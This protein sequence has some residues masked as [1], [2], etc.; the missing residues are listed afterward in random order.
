MTQVINTTYHALDSSAALN[1]RASG[2]IRAGVYAGYRIRPN[3]G[4]NNTLDIIAGT[5]SSSIL[6][7]SQGIRIEETESVLGAVAIDAADIS[8]TRVD[9]VVASYTYQSS[10]SVPQAYT[11][12]KGRNQVNTSSDP[13]KPTVANSLQIP[14]AYVTVRPK[15]QFSGVVTSRIEVTDIEHVPNANWPDANT[16][17]VVAPG[18]STRVYVYPGIFLS[19]DQRSVVEFPGGY[20]DAQDA[21]LYT[22]NEVRYIQFGLTDEGLVENV[23]ES[24]TLAA[25]PALTRDVFPVAIAKVRKSFNTV[26]IESLTD[27]RFPY[28]RKHSK[29]DEEDDYK[30]L[31]ADSVFKSMRVERLVDDSAIDLD[32]VQ[33][34]SSGTISTLTAAID[35]KDTS[36]TLTWAGTSALPS[37]AV[38]ISTNELLTGGNTQTLSH[39][40]IAADA[41][42]E[43]IRYQYSTS[44]SDSGFTATTYRL[45]E[46]VRIPAGGSTRLYLRF[47]FPRIAFSGTKQAKL[48][49]FAVLMNLDDAVLNAN[50]V[51]ELGIAALK[52]SVNNLIPNGNFYYWSR[53]DIN[54]SDPDLATTGDINF[55][56]SEYL[57]EINAADGWQVTS[58]GSGPQNNMVTRTHLSDIGIPSTIALK[59]VSTVSGS[60]TYL[61]TR[62]PVG[63]DLR[64]R[65]LTFASNYKTGSTQ[66]V[67]I[68]IALYTRTASGLVLSTKY[69]A[70]AQSLD[71]TLVVNT[72]T[73]VGSSITEIGF[74]YIFA[75]ADEVE[76]RVWDARAVS[77][78]FG[79]IPFTPVPAAPAAIRQFYERGR[80]F[81][82][83]AASEGAVV[84]FSSQFGTPKMQSGSLV[85]RVFQDANAN[86]SLNVS[87]ISLD[88]KPYGVLVSSS[89]TGSGT[90]VLDI[91][92][93]AYVIYENSPAS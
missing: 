14:L 43:G 17:P 7:T 8:L 61:E 88:A 65:G 35:S 48:F 51:G 90:A 54:G 13:V 86:R 63:S 28:A 64:G 62:V 27:I 44:G 58:F 75:A 69:E 23:G 45:N 4:S 49:S 71:G 92:W 50:T 87:N 78:T 67:G 91:D 38:T 42:V 68:G 2:V 30:D 82:S 21:T 57:D 20:S 83:S 18:A 56:L 80:T 24:S 5:D 66:A 39:F 46:I 60:A 70:M 55:S 25:L 84:A 37:E 19:V 77:G 12:I 59:Y 73:I 81:I 22:D 76:T 74:Y 36:L 41:P 11:V 52:N 40:M 29:V 93:E 16:K 15:N 33:L 9:L 53:L 72:D 26:N 32:S 47:I 10:G 34:E 6:M 85:A 89:A 79:N 31:L 1:Q 3:G